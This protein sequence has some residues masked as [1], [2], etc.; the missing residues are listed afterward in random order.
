MLTLFA[1]VVAAAPTASVVTNP[2]EGQQNCRRASA[3]QV[4][5]LADRLYAQGAVAAAEQA[6]EALTHDPSTD[7]R[8]EA[9]FR[10]AALREK[11]GDLSGSAD[12]LRALLRERPDAQ[13]ARLEL[14]RILARTGDDRG[15]RREL[16]RAAAGG[17]PRDL[18]RTVRQFSSAL[19]SL[20]TR[21]ASL[22]LAVAP[23][24]NIN[25]S[26]SNETIDTAIAPFRLDQ[27]ARGQSGIGMSLVGQLWS[28]NSAVGAAILSQANV[29]S[30]LYGKSRFNDVQ[31][32]VSSGPELATAAGRIRPAVV[33]ERRWY[34]GSPYSTG[35]GASFNW[36]IIPSAQ[37]QIEVDGSVIHQSVRRNN[38]LNG[39]RYG[40]GATAD[41]TLSADTSARLS[42]RGAA[43]NAA[44]AAESLRQAG[45]DLVLAHRFGI[46]TAFGQLGYTRTKGRAP[47][48][49]FG[50]TREDGRLDLGAGFIAHTLQ[51]RGF[52][53]MVRAIYTAS[54]SNIGLYEF[55]RR[56]VEIGLSRDF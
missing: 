5:A 44:A 17:L 29:R 31:L 34:G 4:F 2:C 30:D 14:S 24:S 36:L 38:W 16:R 35:Y 6:L 13:A 51:Y 53:P 47:I 42:L 32:T 49:L 9:R 20:K 33:H 12:S 54:N 48:P 25:R 56:R 1:A 28:R 18:E 10:L 8:A 26:T 3:A 21:G 15:A 52:A 27:D 46:A 50:K 19:D 55:R 39:M 43:L 40:I 22:E 37:S 45:A 11:R 7:L 41:Y 23:D